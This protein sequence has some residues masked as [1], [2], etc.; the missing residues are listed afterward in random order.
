MSKFK[1]LI[2]AGHGGMQDG[3][4]TTAPAKMFTFHD[5]YT[6]YEGVVNRKIADKL[7]KL[8]LINKIDFA[9]VYDE[10]KD[11]S[12][13][14]RVEIANKL[15][16]KDKRCMYLSIHSNAGGG[17][18][19]EVYTSKGQTKS[20][21]L[22]PH[23]INAYKEAFKGYKLRADNSD[24]DEDKE[25]DFYVVHKTNCPAV[26]VESFFFDNRMEAEFLNSEIGQDAIAECLLQAILNIEKDGTLVN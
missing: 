8:L 22:A 20:D 7:H 23:F 10:V 16:A 3:V 21:L 4:Y 12:L 11:T 25:A 2:D 19:I 18:G 9:L 13:A 6:I 26:L 24:G 17:S 1:Y 14:L 5:G 15:Y